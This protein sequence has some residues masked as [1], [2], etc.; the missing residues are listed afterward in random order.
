VLSLAERLI[1]LAFSA[2][3]G[4]VVTANGNRTVYVLRLVSPLGK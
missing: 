1:E 3:G 4:H 2:E